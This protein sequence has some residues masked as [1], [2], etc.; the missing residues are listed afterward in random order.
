VHLLLP[1]S[2]EIASQWDAQPLQGAYPTSWWRM[3]E[4]VSDRVTLSLKGVPRGSYRLAIGLYHPSTD[5]RL[6]VTAPSGERIPEGRLVLEKVIRWP[7][8]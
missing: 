8:P 3:G 2:E 6:P 7:G 1:D 4:V 5:E